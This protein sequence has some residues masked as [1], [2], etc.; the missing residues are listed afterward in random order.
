MRSRSRPQ[1]ERRFFAGIGFGRVRG[2]V[3]GATLSVIKSACGVDGNAPGPG[4]R[5]VLPFE[6]ALESRWVPGLPRWCWRQVG[7]DAFEVDRDGGQDVLD[8][9]LVLAAVAAQ[10]HAVAVDELADRALRGQPAAST[11]T[12]APG[13][14]AQSGSRSAGRRGRTAGRRFRASVRV[15]AVFTGPC[16]QSSGE[17]DV[18]VTRTSATARGAA[19]SSTCWT[20][21]T[22]GRALTM[23][24]RANFR[25]KSVSEVR[26]R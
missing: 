6:Q 20:L 2:K 13:A 7:T 21:R 5:D 9:S 10:A 8:V 3:V 26:C 25:L 12:A 18:D 15:Q 11:A 4:S 17:L 16:R 19:A 24:P 1:V 22:G 23:I 14:A